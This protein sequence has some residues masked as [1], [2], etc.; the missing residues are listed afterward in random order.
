M[1]AEIRRLGNY[2]AHADQGELLEWISERGSV[3]GA[4]FLNHGEDDARAGLK[5]L[6]VQKGW[7]KE[8]VFSPG[9]GETFDLVAGSAQSLGSGPRRIEE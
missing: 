7:A 5:D 1:A 9:F 2:S 3:S 8:R 4:I 6:L